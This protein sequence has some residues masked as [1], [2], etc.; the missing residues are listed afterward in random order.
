MEPNPFYEGLTS[1]PGI[2]YLTD[3][4]V[5]ARTVRTIFPQFFKEIKEICF[6][7]FHLDEVN[8]FLKQ[9]NLLLINSLS[10]YHLKQ[11][12]CSGILVWY[13]VVQK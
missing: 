4:V 11:F 6:S 8:P 2:C 5:T 13:R 1:F 9:Q 7:Y 3:F 10:W 12:A